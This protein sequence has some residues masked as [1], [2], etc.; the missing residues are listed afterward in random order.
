MNTV[1]PIDMGAV[2]RHHNT[3]GITT[4]QGKKN[5]EIIVVVESV[6]LHLRG[7]Q[8]KDNNI[9]NT[10][11]GHARKMSLLISI[12]YDVQSRVREVFSRLTDTPAHQT[13]WP[14]EQNKTR[15]CAKRFIKDTPLQTG[16]TCKVSKAI[17][18]T[19]NEYVVL[20]KGILANKK[21]LEREYMILKYLGAH[22]N[23]AKIHEKFI[24]LPNKQVCLVMECYDGGDLVDILA[25]EECGLAKRKFL[26]YARQLADGLAYIHS[27]GIAHR[28]LKG[29]NVCTSREDGTIKIVDFG[30]A[31]HISEPIT[32]L[33][34]GTLHY[35][36]PELVAAIESSSSTQ[37]VGHQEYDLLKCDIY[38]LGITFYSMITSQLPFEVASV[39]DERFNTFVNTCSMGPCA[40]WLRIPPEL[41]ILLVGM[42]HFKPNLR[43]NI[44]MVCKYLQE[45]DCA[46]GG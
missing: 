40:T 43:W 22:P 14:R 1:Q 21:K 8:L 24:D 18:L 4:Y 33:R 31:Q 23:I 2:K 16:S 26:N 37:V 39:N 15:D 29:D 13:F 42:C 34:R 45:V 5:L 10:A 27:R 28:D 12:P 17:D 7:W 44:Q 30:E 20:K 41:K 46:V 35:L 3:P 9:G 19:T 6:V 36:A 38:S 25:N 11:F 32:C